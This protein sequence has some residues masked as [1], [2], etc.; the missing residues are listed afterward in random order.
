MLDEMRHFQIEMQAWN[1]FRIKHGY[2][3]PY[4][5]DRWPSMWSR[6][7]A[8]NIFRAGVE[9]FI[10]N[11][12]I[13]NIVFLQMFAETAATNV[14]GEEGEGFADPEASPVED[15]D[16]HPVSDPGRR[17]GGTSPQQGGDLLGA[18]HLGR[19]GLALVGRH[20]IPVPG[21]PH[22]GWG[23]GGRRGGLPGASGGGLHRRFRPCQA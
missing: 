16:E 3:D 18:E 7:V 9:N 5:F 8:G 1:R 14:L 13:T 20:P 23:N 17:P 2:I 15:G 21:A 6:N 4:G 11:D 12:P 19:V 22:G 10:T